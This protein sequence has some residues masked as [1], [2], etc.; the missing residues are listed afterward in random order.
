MTADSR[1]SDLLSIA[2]QV[3]DRAL[4]FAADNGIRVCVVVLDATFTPVALARRDGAYASTVAVA[5]AKAHTAMNFGAPTHALKERIVP[6]NQRALSSVEPRLMFVG[7]G[8]PIVDGDRVVGAVGVSGGSEDQ[9]VQ[10]AQHAL[11]GLSS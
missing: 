1:S 3:V 11:E 8:L 10:C 7:G 2:S 4:A 6:E 5:T 9:D